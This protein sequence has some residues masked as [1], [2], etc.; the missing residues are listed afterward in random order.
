MN[1]CTIIAIVYH[2]PDYAETR[3][4]IE[5]TGLPVH[6]VERNPKGVGSLAEAINRGVREA[7]ESE[8]FWI[9]TNVTFNPALVEDLIY[10]MDIM[11]DYAAIHP[12]FKSDH[13]FMR[14]KDMQDLAPTPFVEFTA[15][16]V[17]YVPIVTFPLDERMPYWGFD[18]DWCHTVKTAGYQVGV[19]HDMELGHSYI[20]FKGGGN[21][22]TKVRLRKR[23]LTDESTRRALH[24][25]YGEFWKQ[26]RWPVWPI[27]EE[28]K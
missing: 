25:K 28:V 17:R 7:P 24:N 5:A 18:F 22:Y 15:P 2:E 9:V 3:K 16:M 23:K 14:K 6:W 4:C 10:Q 20:R 12:A 11:P 21:S 8:Y 27:A 13:E 19:F 1:K 26:L